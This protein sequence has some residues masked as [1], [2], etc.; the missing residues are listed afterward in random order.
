MFQ[1][2]K[3]TVFGLVRFLASVSQLLRWLYVLL[4]PKKEKP[5]LKD[6]ITHSIPV[7][8]QPVDSYGLRGF[9]VPICYLKFVAAY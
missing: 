4:L 5:E 8:K 6:F 7:V 9:T 3:L 2:V 1:T